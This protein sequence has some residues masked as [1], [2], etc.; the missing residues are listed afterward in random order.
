MNNS[1][2]KKLAFSLIKKYWH[3]APWIFLLKKV[4]WHKM[5]MNKAGAYNHYEKKIKLN[6]AMLNKP[7]MEEAIEDTLLHELIHVWQRHNPDEKIQREAPHGKGFRSEMYRINSILQR[8]A[9]TIYHN[10][11]MTGN[12]RILRKAMG[13]LARTQSNNEHEAAIAVAKF[14]EYMQRYDLQLSDEALILANELPELEDQVVAISRVADTWRKV[15]LSSLAYI[16][17][18]KLFWRNKNGFVEWHCIGREHRLDNIVVLYDYLEEAIE[19]F[20]HTQQKEARHQGLARGRAY[21]NSFRVGIS[22]TIDQ[23]LQ[24]DFKTRINQGIKVDNGANISALMIKNWHTS[25]TENLNNFANQNYSFKKTKNPNLSSYHGYHDG[26]NAGN[27]INL[28]RQ[29]KSKSYKKLKSQ[30]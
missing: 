28:N 13:L 7:N 10:Y 1:Q 29:V 23:R 14:T 20:V 18:S 25:E 12:D 22:L 9:V 24:L 15:L 16:N 6:S 2:L 8:D 3:H 19:R 5:A 21:W 11:Q 30:I 4:E 27:K 26:K 17:A